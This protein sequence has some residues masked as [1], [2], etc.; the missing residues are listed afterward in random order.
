MKSYSTSVPDYILALHFR[1]FSSTLP[2]DLTITGFT[3]ERLLPQKFLHN[4]ALL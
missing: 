4:T 2:N 1:K 3:E